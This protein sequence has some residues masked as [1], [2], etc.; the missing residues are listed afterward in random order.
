MSGL[1][2]HLD[3]SALRRIKLS[4]QVRAATRRTAED[5]ARAVEAQGHLVGDVDVDGNTRQIPLP[6]LVQEGTAPDGSIGVY[7]A[8]PAGVAE[9]AKNGVLARAA[10]AEGLGLGGKPADGI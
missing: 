2:V 3:P 10:A 4:S 6:V 8:H 5:V 9:E 1:D 7:L